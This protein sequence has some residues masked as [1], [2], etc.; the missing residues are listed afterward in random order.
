MAR[1]QHAAGA[2]A[3]AGRP[4]SLI[5]SSSSAGSWVSRRAS[6]PVLSA[7][8][9][10]SAK[11]HWGKTGDGTHR[12]GA[13]QPEQASYVAQSPAA[14]PHSAHSAH[15]GRKDPRSA[16]RSPDGAWKSAGR[17]H[18]RTPS[19]GTRRD[20]LAMEEEQVVLEIIAEMN[21]R[22]ES[23]RSCGRVLPTPQRRAHTPIPP[24]NQRRGY[25][26]AAR[27]ADQAPLVSADSSTA[28]DGGGGMPRRAAVR[29]DH[30]AGRTRRVP[31]N[32]RLA[33]AR[34]APVVIHRRRRRRSVRRAPPPAACALGISR[35]HLAGVGGRRLEAG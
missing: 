31:R 6:A 33:N 35:A 18:R 34:S 1:V 15:S 16:G 11:V 30:V 4:P 21:R 12:K 10:A 17:G 20:T 14:A 32:R 22:D 5:H 19:S 2:P 8:S 24:G 23:P 13:Q 25:L 9:A 7:S 26:R 3:A 29:I 28:N 27:A